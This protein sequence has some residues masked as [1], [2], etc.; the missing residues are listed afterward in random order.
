MNKETLQELFEYREGNLYWKVVNSNRIKVG[1]KAGYV[2]K[3]GYTEVRI[4]NKLYLLHRLIYAYHYGDFAGNVDHK[5]NNTS[6]NNIDNLR[7]CTQSNNMCNAKKQS[8]NTSGNKGVTF[9]KQTGKWRGNIT[10]EG[11]DYWL[12]RFNS[13]EEA[14]KAVEQA[15]ITIHKEFAN[16]G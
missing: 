1:D 14:I 12:G 15:R 16:H 6:N 11:I 4:N 2:N 8:N 3:L 9:C 7:S 5:D 13:K 10:K